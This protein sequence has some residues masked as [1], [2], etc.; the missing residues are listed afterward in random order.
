MDER[1]RENLERNK[2]A[3]VMAAGFAAFVVVYFLI[4]APALDWRNGVAARADTLEAALAQAARAQRDESE[5]GQRIALGVRRFGDTQP[6]GAVEARSLTLNERVREVLEGAGV[7]TWRSDARAP[8]SVRRSDATEALLAADPNAQL[9]RLVVD[10]D[11]SARASTVTEVL[12]A[13]ERSPEI[14]GL[15]RVILRRLDA[16]RGGLVQA[17]VSAEAWVLGRRGG[18]R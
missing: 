18:T 12:T 11:F 14:T 2:R 7:R 17:T 16:E 6:P 5:T 15:G 3:L 10:L 9:Q 4:L 8:S 1:L 13:L